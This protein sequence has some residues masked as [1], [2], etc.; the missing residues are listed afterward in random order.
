MFFFQSQFLLS[1]FIIAIILV[2]FTCVIMN[3]NVRSRKLS[4]NNLLKV[5]LGTLIVIIGSISLCFTLLFGYN[6]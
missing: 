1:L 6:I 4:F 3:L 2:G 5:I